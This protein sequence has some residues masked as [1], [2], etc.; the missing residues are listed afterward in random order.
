MDASLECCVQCHGRMRY[1]HACP[2]VFAQVSDH[3]VRTRGRLGCNMQ[4]R[5]TQALGRLNCGPAESLP[6]RQA[7]SRLPFS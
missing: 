1:K 6:C 2:E 3:C 5:I 4:E 7:Y